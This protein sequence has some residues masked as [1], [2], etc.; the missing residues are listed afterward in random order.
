LDRLKQ[1]GSRLGHALGRFPARKI[2]VALAVFIT[3]LGLL[4]FAHVETSARSVGAALGF[5]NNVELR[6]LD[7][8][9]RI[10]GPR[11]HDERIVI[12]DIDEKTLQRAGAWPI[13]RS[14]YARMLDRLRA[15]GARVVAFDAAFPT[16]EKN[17]AL[18]ALRRLEREIGRGA[19]PDIIQ[20]IRAIESTSD[21]DRLFADAIRKADN[22]VLG[23]IF[24]DAERARSQDAAAA[25]DYYII[26]WDHSFPNLLKA[27]GRRDFDL[28]KVWESVEGPVMW[29]IESNIRL[30]A[31]AARSYGFFNKDPDP[32]G[33]IRH[34]VLLVRYEYQGDKAF[35]AS[36][37]FEALRV[38]D[39]I[40]MASVAGYLGEN[41]MESVAA[42][43]YRFHTQRDASGLINYTGPYGTYRHYSMIDVIDGAVP[44]AE[45]KDKIVFVGATALGIGDLRTTPFNAL[46]AMGVEIHANVLDNMLNSD[47][48]RRG[49]L[50][51]GDTE[52]FIDLAMIVV[53]GLGLGYLFGWLKPLT[54]TLVAVASLG[55]FSGIVYLAFAKFGM[56][57]SFVI[58]AGTMLANYAAITSFRMIFEEREKRKIRKSFGSYVSP[59][60]I[61]LIERDPKKYFRPGGEMKEMS[62]MFSDIRSF[63]SISERM[64]PD[65]LVH[66]L[67]EY[68]GEMT[69]VIFKRW[70]TLDKY[71]GDAIMAFW[72]SPYP[73]PDHALRACGCALDMTA[74]LEE[75]NRKWQSSGKTPI[76]T[77]I[78]INTG[79]V[80]VGNMGSDK[81]MSWTVIGDHVNLASRL[82]G[83]TKDYRCRILC[84]EGTFLAAQE[85]YIFRDLDRIRVQGKF[86][87][88]KVYELLGFA[89]SAAQYD[90]LLQRWDAAV[91]RYRAGRWQDTMRALEEL[92]HTYPDDG[93]AY[94]LLQ[95]CHDKL[96]DGVPAGPWDGVYVAK[97][98]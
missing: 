9:F 24:L 54:A 42:G 88:V 41:G 56:W 82:E 96:A 97:S 19:S 21:N 18:E 73:Q 58:P 33:T 91:A 11:P 28:H 77:G 5:V 72:G 50:R 98:K 84:G 38:Y 37:P 69:S 15:G 80:K 89:A 83:Q 48:P 95:R 43:R 35:Y 36:L 23:H 64:T 57:L 76:A 47:Q 79:P 13:P 39:D 46:N 45:F 12:V 53:L 40:K 60:V 70:G 87:P 1:F 68:L 8:R 4:V 75:L 59:G 22:V 20:K 71:I 94:T 55:L 78:G 14:A 74:R 31:E 86:E 25:K 16:P 26:L 2:D 6:S 52:V 27:K 51:R 66:F 65:D 44:P 62:I 92:L 29:G 30:L 93:P 67:N 17:S 49:F 7:A 85:H 61:N 10:R 34:A 3:A 81:R 90:N 32:D 63:T